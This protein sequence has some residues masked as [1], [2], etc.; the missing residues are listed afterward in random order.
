MKE[1]RRQRISQLYK[2]YQSLKPNK[3]ALL[4][5]LDE[6]ELPERVYNSNAIEN[7][8][9]SL[10][11]TEKILLTQQVSRQISLRE[12]FETKNLA[13]VYGYIKKAKNLALTPETILLLHKMLLTNIKDE[14]AGRFRQKDE[15]VRVGSHI[16]V[17]GEFV[18]QR[19]QEATIEFEADLNNSLLFRI[20]RFHCWFENIH[21]FSDGNGRIGRVLNNLLLL[22]QGF[23]VIIVRNKN[24][25]QYYQAL[26]VFDNTHNCQPMTRVIELALLESL[27]KR[28][29]FLKSEKIM[30]LAEYA[31]TQKQSLSTLLNAARRQTVPVFREKGVWKIGVAN[32]PLGNG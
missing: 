17:P 24:K 26:R 7:S 12:I 27:H 9:L 28:L 15:L 13:L 31:K 32:T 1:T 19:L 14:I 30:P 11:E 21:P 6:A 5:I 3:Q 18:S 29:A 16:A 23:P 4:D 22:K 20:A 25:E 2:Q 8:T 10:P